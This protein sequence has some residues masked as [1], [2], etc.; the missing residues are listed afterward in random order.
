MKSAPDHTGKSTPETEIWQ[1]LEGLPT[2]EQESSTLVLRLANLMA[3]LHTGIL[4]ENE[5]RKIVLTNQKFCDLF[6]I[7]ANPEQLIG[8]D[9]SQSAEQ[10]KHLFKN[11]GEFLSRIQAVLQERKSVTGEL[12]ELADGRIFIR[13]YIP[14][15]IEKEFKGNLWNYT[16]VTERQQQERLLRKN[17]EKYRRLI[18]NIQL[19]L[20]EV[21]LEENIQYVN[22]AFCLLSGYTEQELLGK[23]ILSV[24][25]LTPDNLKQIA[26]VRERRKKGIADVYEIEVVI[27][28]GELRWWAISGAPLYNDSNEVIGSIGIHLDITH[29]KNLE[30]KLREA[31]ELAEQSA[32]AKESFLANMS[33]EIR[34]PLSG[35]Y[36]ML[37]LLQD[38]RLNQEQR[39]YLEHIDKSIENLQTIINDILDLSK[40]NAGMIAIDQVNFSLQE[41]LLSIYNIQRLKA[42]AKGLELNIELDPQLKSAYRGDPHRITQVMNNLINNAIK[43]TEEGGITIHCTCQPISADED[44]VQLTITDTGIGMEEDFLAVIYDKFTQE[45]RGHSQKLG[46]TGL[47]MSI[48]RHLTEL[49]GGH[50]HISSEKYKGTTVRIELPLPITE[51]NT[52]EVQSDSKAG[53]LRN[54]KILIAEDNEINL[55]V[56]KSMLQREGAVVGEVRNGKALIE[57]LAL[58]NY[59]TVI[60]DLQMPIL[61]GLEAARWIRN[62]Y[63]RPIYLVALTANTLNEDRYQC[64]AA[65]FDDILFKPFRREDLI[66]VCLKNNNDQLMDSPEW[67]FV[68]TDHMLYDLSEIREMLDHDEEKIKELVSQFIKETPQK[69]TLLQKAVESNNLEQVRRNAHYLLSSVQHLG[70]SSALKDLEILEQPVKLSSLNKLQETVDHLLRILNQAI[71]QLKEYFSR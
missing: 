52:A 67:G 50:I 8:A 33:H 9:C 19:G 12:L 55:Q 48:C 40:I 58:E 13:D 53:R 17:E 69:M 32:E 25:Q 70:I 30:A 1:Y 11:P 27:K 26:A 47:G 22:Q 45:G 66:T 18:T 31:K 49:M 28:G 23:K 54:R 44:I 5:Y 63:S 51:L 39:T 57:T 46:G 68:S 43:F 10:T 64:L 37:Q 15:F 6:Q 35:I 36:G 59:D 2:Q 42:Q 62:H 41:E 21:D 3:H 16:D 38:T 7:P 61:D 20:V 34:T 24:L 56:I 65:G 14:I 4:V 71:A 60:S 29:Q